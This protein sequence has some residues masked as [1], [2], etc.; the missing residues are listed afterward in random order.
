MRALLALVLLIASTTASL[1]GTATI[2][3]ERIA[4]DYDPVRWTVTSL[5]D[6]GV[7]FACL[8]NDCR[9][10]RQPGHGVTVRARPAGTGKP[11]PA[12]LEAHLEMRDVEPMWSTGLLRQPVPHDFGG[13]AVTGY[14]MFSRCR[15]Y[16]PM[17]QY[18]F[19][20]HGEH[21]Y[22]FAS[23]FNAGCSGVEGVSRERFAELL[24]GVHIVG[25]GDR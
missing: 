19:G 12:A 17:M 6:G 7:K 4:I 1:A 23:G 2:Q 20:T 14:R 25:D 22:V 16:T 21:D 11:T 10:A 8:G 13:I 18:A 15:A 5:P 3:I 24:G 9:R